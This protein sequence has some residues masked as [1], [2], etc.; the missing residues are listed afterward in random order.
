MSDRVRAIIFDG[1]YVLLIRRRKQGRQYWVFPGGE[2]EQSDVS[3]AAALR[4]EC[5]EELGVEVMADDQPSLTLGN[6]RFY[7]CRIIGG[8]VGTGTG[9]EFQ[10]DGGYIGTYN[11]EWVSLASLPNL[12]LLPSQAKQYAIERSRP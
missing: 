12:D 11:L 5:R 3:D 9:P 1:D 10:S 8:Q 2:V 6:E 4:R 7:I